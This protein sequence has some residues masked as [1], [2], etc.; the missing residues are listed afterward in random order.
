MDYEL[1]VFEVYDEG[2]QPSNRKHTRKKCRQKGKLSVV[3]DGEGVGAATGSKNSVLSNER[4]PLSWRQ[5]ILSVFGKLVVWRNQR[6]YQSA[7]PDRATAA[8]IPHSSKDYRRGYIPC[9]K[10]GIHHA[11]L[12][13]G[14]SNGNNCL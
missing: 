3:V 9:G 8:D 12:E 4:R 14:G 10:Y 13:F 2:E 6:R 1:E 7:V 11:I 5:S